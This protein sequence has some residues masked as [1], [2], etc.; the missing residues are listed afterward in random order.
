MTGA[1]NIDIPEQ[2][3]NKV[4]VKTIKLFGDKK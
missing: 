2:V 4:W 3:Y 1:N